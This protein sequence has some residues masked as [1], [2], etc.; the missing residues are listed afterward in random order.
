MEGLLDSD[1]RIDVSEVTKQVDFAEV[2]ALYFP[3]LRKTLLMDWRTNDVDGSMIRVVPMANTAE[4]RF[5]SLL[6]MRPR[7]GRPEAIVIIPWPKYVTSL[8]ELGIWDHIVRR[9]A[10]TGSAS[11]VRDCERCFNELERLER[12]EIHRAITGKNYETI[13][14][15]PGVAEAVLA[16]D[17][18]E[19]F[20]EDDDLEDDV[21][22]EDD[23]SG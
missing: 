7:F 17:D 11:V 18:D 1:Y 12:E 13:W 3:L 10:D 5:Q 9:Y 2:I 14:G 21:L 23:L 15:K 16:D 19:D 8:A 22:D 6:K 20:D 4:E